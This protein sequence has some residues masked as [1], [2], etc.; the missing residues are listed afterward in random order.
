[1]RTQGAGKHGCP[2]VLVSV[3]HLI[4]WTIRRS[5]L[6]QSES[7]FEKN[8]MKTGITFANQLNFFNCE[9]Y[10]RR[11]SCYFQKTK[12]WIIHGSLTYI[13]FDE[14]FFSHHFKNTKPISNTALFVFI[15]NTYRHFFFTMAVD[16][17]VREPLSIRLKL[18]KITNTSY[19]SQ[20]SAILT[21]SQK[22]FSREKQLQIFELW[23][24]TTFRILD[25]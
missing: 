16:I 17:L 12:N 6:D 5:F 15:C 11:W 4:G 21:I 19:I 9:T 22:K 14:A 8:P 20:H 10:P 2:I 25:Q 23:T 24:V 3:L 13:V 7:E 18:T 1:M